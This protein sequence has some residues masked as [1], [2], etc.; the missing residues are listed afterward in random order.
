[1]AHHAGL[2]QLPW[3]DALEWRGEAGVA[4]R[5]DG[6]EEQRLLVGSEDSG[7]VIPT[8]GYICAE[9]LR[10]HVFQEAHRDNVA[11]AARILSFPLQIPYLEPAVQVP[12]PP[13]PL[14]FSYFL[15]FSSLQQLAPFDQSKQLNP[16][17]PALGLS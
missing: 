10:Q 5:A 4:S 12:P 15:C 9:V 17:Y 6:E 2:A 8:L 13:P 1:M 11:P 16:F 7:Y 3:Y 14:F